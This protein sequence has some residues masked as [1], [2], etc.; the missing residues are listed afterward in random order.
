MAAPPFMKAKSILALLAGCSLLLLLFK[1]FSVPSAPPAPARQLA[2]ASKSSPVATPLPL[3]FPA[4]SS[5][6]SNPVERTMATSQLLDSAVTQVDAGNYKRRQLIKIDFHPRAVYAEEQWRFES[7]RWI[8]LSRD[9]YAAD[10][11]IVKFKTGTD[12]SVLGDRLKM[13][14]YEI[15]QRLDDD[16]YT[17][18]LDRAD[19]QSVPKALTNLATLPNL[20]E[21][22]EPDGVGFGGGVPND[23]RFSEQWG[24]HNTGQSG[25]AANADVDGPEFWDVMETATNVLIAVIDSGLNFTHP[26]LQGI[27]WQNAGEIAGDGMDNDGSGKI[28]DVRGWDFTNNDNDPTDDHGH[29]SNVTGIIAAK[30]NNG[31]G[32][33]G[34]IS[35]A[36]ILVCKVLDANN[37]GFTSHLIAAVTYARQ[38]GATI[39]NLSLQ[40]YP[41]SSALNAEFTTC[42]NAGVLLCI[43]AGNQGVDNDINPNYPSSY[44]QTNIIAVANHDR[45]DARWSGS[46]NPSNYGVTSVDLFAPG[47]DIVSPVLGTAYSSYTGSS[48]STPYVTAVAA[49]LKALNPTWKAAELKAAIMASVWTRPAYAGICVSSGRLNA[50]RAVSVAIRSQPAS[51]KDGDGFANL[52][53][54]AA[55][56]RLDSNTNRPV[57]TSRVEAGVLKI[58]LARAVR[59]DA[60]LQVETTANLTNQWS[61]AGVIDSS[62]PTLLS[63]G[64][65]L[66]RSSSG[67][68]RISATAP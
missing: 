43:C 5:A 16:L 44:T 60:L 9:L 65:S 56:T 11:L 24:V 22:A 12:L 38:R 14:G 59:P 25:G 51:D 15:E 13:F 33:A 55:G 47:R 30:K 66:G 1:I 26:D 67:F 20:V 27:A 50:L 63:G 64:V 39:M 58:E 42:Q 32:I 57:V 41:F 68:L 2:T 3:P 7:N 29:G 45:T 34:M 10:Q 31:L 36:P 62:S 23:S 35:G 4:P 49:A 28:D 54:Y 52:F 61:G 17:V 37:S 18:R 8:C 6:S 48:Q 46:F 19:L 53:E 21:A 40:S